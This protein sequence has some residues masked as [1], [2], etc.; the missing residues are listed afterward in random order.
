MRWV[1]G[2]PIGKLSLCDSPCGMGTFGKVPH[3]GIL[4]VFTRGS[5]HNQT[6]GVGAFL[7]F[8]FN[9]SQSNDRSWHVPHSSRPLLNTLWAPRTAPP[10]YTGD[11]G[12]RFFVYA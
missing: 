12:H 6:F 2:F 1:S 5:C 8:V 10:L 7:C 9:G 3:S 4:H 11:N